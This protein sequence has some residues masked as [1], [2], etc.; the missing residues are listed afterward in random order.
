[1]RQWLS[2]IDRKLMATHLMCAPCRHKHSIALSLYELG[3]CDTLLLQL[4]YVQVA[5]KILLTDDWVA[6][7]MSVLP[8]NVVAQL[9]RMMVAENGPSVYARSRP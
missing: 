7:V 5:Q 3:D 2:T 9:V 6:V 1:M 4:K 8:A